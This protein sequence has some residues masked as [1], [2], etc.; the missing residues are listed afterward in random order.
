LS[1][2]A[3]PI[4]SLLFKLNTVK[5]FTLLLGIWTYFKERKTVFMELFSQLLLTIIKKIKATTS[6]LSTMTTRLVYAV[7]DSIKRHFSAV[8]DSKN[9]IISEIKK[10]QYTQMLLD[11]MRLCVDVDNC[12]EDVVA[13]DDRQN[14]GFL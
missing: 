4:K 11:E 12:N 7:K 9:V 5:C 6:G 8:F 13:E 14:Q 2:A 10:D 1:L 3:L